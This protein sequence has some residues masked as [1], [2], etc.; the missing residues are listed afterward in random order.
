MI[1]FYKRCRAR[2][3]QFTGNESGAVTMEFLII[4]PFLFWGYMA[5]LTYYDAFRQNTV[6]QKAAFTIADLISRQATVNGAFL[7]GAHTV[8]DTLVRSNTPTALRVTSVTYN[9]DDPEDE[10][11]GTY[12][13]LW[14]EP[15]GD[16]GELTTDDVENWHDVLPV[17][18]D[19]A[20]VVVVETW[21]G[22]RP[23]FKIG[24]SERTLHNFTFTRPRYSPQVCFEDSCD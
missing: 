18:Y 2:V 9:D 14:S 3:A 8:F 17:M 22:F 5:M 20:T 11:L 21:A 7:D 15:R 1:D 13:V 23:A 6:N 16:F 19:G 12:S 24:M 10:T 4:C